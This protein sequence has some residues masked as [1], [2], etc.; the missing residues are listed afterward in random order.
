M[1]CIFRGG[2]NKVVEVLIQIHYQNLRL[3]VKPVNKIGSAIPSFEQI[4][5][6][7]H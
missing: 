6:H 7:L 2:K 5:L 1:N 3:K 4:N